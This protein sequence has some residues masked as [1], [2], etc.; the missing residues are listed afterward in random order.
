MKENNAEKGQTTRYS[1]CE[2][3]V[4]I[5]IWNPLQKLN[6]FKSQGQKHDRN[7]CFMALKLT[8]SEKKLT[9]QIIFNFARTFRRQ[10]PSWP[11]S[12]QNSS[13]MASV[14]KETGKGLEALRT[15]QNDDTIMLS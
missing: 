1:G 10:A 5:D 15:A 8:V 6:R 4:V 13:E 14:S 11:Q 3:F 2:S 7:E 12:Y 9:V